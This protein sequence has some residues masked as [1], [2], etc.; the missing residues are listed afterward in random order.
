[1]KLLSVAPISV[2]ALALAG[3]G[4]SLEPK[5]SLEIDGVTVNYV[6]ETKDG[7]PLGL[8]FD[9]EIANSTA[10]NQIPAYT[11]KWTTTEIEGT[12][13][14]VT[15][16]YAGSHVWVAGVSAIDNDIL[17]FYDSDGAEFGAADFRV[18]YLIPTGNP[19]QPVLYSGPFT[20]TITGNAS[21]GPW[22]GEGDQHSDVGCGFPLPEGIESADVTWPGITLVPWTDGCN[23]GTSDEQLAAGDWKWDGDTLTVSNGQEFECV[24]TPMDE[25]VC[26][27]S[28]THPDDYGVE[29]SGEGGCPFEVNAVIWPDIAGTAAVPYQPS[30]YWH[31]K[32]KERLAFDIADECLAYEA[33]CIMYQ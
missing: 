17:R 27:D 20:A 3:C 6:P 10:D 1:M 28:W 7:E 32:A 19:E 13:S 2:A 8:I 30:A 21:F 12:R 26:T 31:V 33:A 24:T 5:L 14:E 23:G 22:C 25:V 4:P 16:T 29:G 9:P 11:Q 18:D 15:M